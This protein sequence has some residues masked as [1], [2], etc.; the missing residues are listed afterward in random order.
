MN[1]KGIFRLGE[2][3]KF[4]QPLHCNDNLLLFFVNVGNPVMIWVTPVELSGPGCVDQV[5]FGDG[6][7]A[8]GICMATITQA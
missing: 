1:G 2:C 5:W 4:N 7:A 3:N 8:R 6:S